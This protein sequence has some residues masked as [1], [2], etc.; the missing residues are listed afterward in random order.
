MN[1]RT[2]QAK[3]FS[4]PSADE[5]SAMASAKGQIQ[6]K[7]YT[8]T[9]PVLL[10]IKDRPVYLI[11]L[12]DGS[13]LA[14]MFALVDAQNY[15][16]VIVGSTVQE[17]MNQYNLR[18]DSSNEP[19]ASSVEKTITVEE[20]QSVVIDGNTVFFVRAKG[21]PLV[22]VGTAKRLGSKLIFAKPGDVLKVFGNPKEKQFDLLELR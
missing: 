16:Q 18:T 12:K 8:P 10:N 17:V 6:E 5:K 22:Y 11:G 2:K 20:I 3:F 1:L 15:Q 9:F 14:K 7:N 19:G 13:G 4:V 21:D